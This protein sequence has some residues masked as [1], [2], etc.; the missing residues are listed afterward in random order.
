MAN[1]KSAL[2]RVRVSSKKKLQNS[3]KRSSLRKT[4]KR[5]NTVIENEEKDNEAILKAVK[6]VDQAV[7]N[8]IVHRN[9]GARDRS[10][11]IKALYK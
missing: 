3:S 2:K 11:L 10:K 4:M 8:G 1:S 7:S 6:A 9:K 5:A